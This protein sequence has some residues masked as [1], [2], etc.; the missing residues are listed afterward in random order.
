MGREFYDFVRCEES[1]GACP[2][3]RFMQHVQ[4]LERQ[5]KAVRRML[6]AAEASGTDS[7]EVEPRDWLTPGGYTHGYSPEG[8]EWPEE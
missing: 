3:C 5:V 6:A 7:T 4:A 8:E 1:C 2:R